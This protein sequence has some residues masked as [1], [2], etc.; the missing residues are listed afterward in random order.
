MEKMTN[1]SLL[2]NPIFLLYA[3][4]NL[5]T[6]IAFNSPLVFLPS[7]A[8]NLRL[9][10][11]QS[12]ISS[13]ISKISTL[14]GI[15][16]TVGRILVGLISDRKLPCK[17]GKDRAQN[18]LWIYVSSLTLCGLLTTGVL[19]CDGYI[20]L[21]MYSGLFGLTLSSYV[22]LTSVL[23]VDLIGIEKL[24]NA[25]GL[26]LLFQGIGTVIGPPISGKNFEKLKIDAIILSKI[27]SFT[28]I[29]SKT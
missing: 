15:M 29:L 12:A 23:L 5:L 7:H 28:T 13:K 27:I 8:T 11:T 18:R 9:T 20:T 24:T 3:I 14:S 22:C 26:I 1:I 10:P 19:F 4:S 2:A 6:S 16:N 25:F 17:Y 21:A